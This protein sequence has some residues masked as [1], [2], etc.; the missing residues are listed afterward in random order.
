MTDVKKAD[1][2][3][4]SSGSLFSMYKLCKQ[5]EHESSH[6]GKSKIVKTFVSNFD[7]DLY[8][9]AKLMLVK[10]DKR[11]Y[12]IKDKAMIKLMA[13]VYQTDY[14]IMLLDCVDGGDFSETVKKF[15]EES[16]T[17]NIP[18][19]STLTLK[20][21]DDFL[22]KLTTI[23]KFND[24]LK[25]IK[26][27]I[28]Y[29]TPFDWKLICRII[30]GDLKI[31]TGAKFFFDGLHP[32]AYQIFKNIN[33]LKI[34]IERIKSG[35]M[36]GDDSDDDNNNNNKSKKSTKKKSKDSDDDDDDSDKDKKK[37]SS[38]TSKKSKDTTLK[39]MTPI[40]P[41]LAKAVK[42]VDGVIKACGDQF[43]AEIK[44]DGERIQIHKDGKTY[45][46]FSRSLKQ[47][48]PY[49]VDPVKPY[50]SKSTQADSI[51]L[52]G[53]ILLVD[54]K[55]NLPLPFGSLSMHKKNQ[56]A[57][58]D[59]CVFLFD[60]LYLN[61]KSLI[62]LPFSERR[63]LLEK[64]VNVIKNR[65]E[66][67]EMTEING[68]KEKSKLNNLLSRAFK[69]KLEG[70]V[71]KDGKGSYE[72]GS[73]HWIKIKKDYLEG[74]SDSADLVCV[75]AYYGTG[76]FGGL[77][78]SFLMCVYDKKDKVYKTVCK[79]SSGFDDNQ[80]KKLQKKL[81]DTMVKIS[82]DQ[83]K[84]PGWVSIN[85]TQ[86]PDFILKDYKDAI[87]LEVE[88]AEFTL[89][90]HHSSGFSMR[91]PRILK[92]RDDKDY[93]T[94]TTYEELVEL[95]KDIKIV[96]LDSDDEDEIKSNI[97]KK[98]ILPTDTTTT[99]TTT[100]TTATS[101]M[102]TK[103]SVLDNTD[104]EDEDKSLKKKVPNGT[105]NDDIFDKI[106]Y[107]F[108]DLLDPFEV[109]RE[110][111]ISLILNFTDNTGEWND[112]G[113]SGAIGKRWKNVIEE[114]V[115]SKMDLG[116][117]VCTKVEN[118]SI[119]DTDSDKK[120]YVLNICCI[121]PTKSKK[122]TF[123]SSDFQ[124]CISSIISHLKSKKAQAIYTFK[125]QIPGADWSDIKQVI[126]DKLINKGYKVFCY[127]NKPITTITSKVDSP[128]TTDIL[129]IKMQT[130]DGADQ[131]A[132]ITKS[133]DKMDIDNGDKPKDEKKKESEKKI[134]SSPN[135]SKKRQLD[136]LE[137]E[138]FSGENEPVLK[139]VNAVVCD[140]GDAKR[141]KTI[142]EL[143]RAMGG[144]V[145][146]EI[147]VLGLKTT[148]LICESKCDEYIHFDRIGGLIVR[149][150][151]V[152]DCFKQDRRVLEAPFIYTVV[153]S[154]TK[155]QDKKV[156]LLNIFMGLTIYLQENVN[157][158]ETLKRYIV[159]YGGQI[160]TDQYPNDKTT[161]YIVPSLNPSVNINLKP[162]KLSPKLTILNSLWIWDSINLSEL[163]PEQD[164]KKVQIK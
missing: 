10:E 76:S 54:H 118:P 11:V 128:V 70:L 26:K 161:H 88:S 131:K 22:D 61:G 33:D 57:D 98:K 99:T 160:V 92:L 137:D 58:A 90:K 89:T 108:G 109:D 45:S 50:I 43:F 34:V 55:T 94:A 150:E 116:E 130:D 158:L 135:A 106:T 111:D 56:F 138:I 122:V 69:E 59:V 25:A 63:A 129:P 5:L 114:F 65:I 162:L 143:I 32:L 147:K 2:P 113:V 100:T 44:Y 17:M 36:D 27:I 75:G 97:Y 93:K 49:K 4:D 12:R 123:S 85:K 132:T 83:S 152:E 74:M 151:W 96:T 38:G 21:V 39:I 7:G 23:S 110:S 18:T 84:V 146:E 91:F 48:M 101:V 1:G 82:K 124:G 64:N 46:C 120:L 163:S 73:R 115:N 35:K 149:P 86:T 71:V 66:L 102:S 141:K 47:V 164:Y 134:S 157:E 14:D 117:Y 6:T 67:S 87:I 103:K 60:I 28:R 153:A 37:K 127:S 79:V 51:I 30:D 81:L 53:E 68:E 154:P 156:R 20:Q 142:S 144:V 31:N 15:Y 16:D 104:S 40:K 121:R 29:C 72:A 62:H 19:R 145:S 139:G 41:M 9:L 3:V 148:H 126:N 77:L 80:V 133:S 95:G 159:A 52:D 125:P 78:T 155:S 112:R 136:A 140:L 13:E 107:V 8:I 105:A 24:Q 42:S 119:F